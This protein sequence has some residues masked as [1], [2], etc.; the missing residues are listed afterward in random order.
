MR[1]V[2]SES[3]PGPFEWLEIIG[4]EPF[5]ATEDYLWGYAVTDSTG[6]TLKFSYDL[7]SVQA[8]VLCADRVISTVVQE[9]LQL[10]R[11]EEQDGYRSIQASCR[12]EGAESTLVITLDPAI[13]ITWSTLRTG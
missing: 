4:V 3:L 12:F 1:R 10:I 6:I 2:S 11:L 9:G 13:N 8:I 7:A 5:L